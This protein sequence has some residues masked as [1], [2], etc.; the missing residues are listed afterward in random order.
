MF[1]IISWIN[2]GFQLYTLMILIRI[3]SSWLPQ[4]SNTKFIRFIAYYTDPYLNFFRRFV[5]PLGMFDF[6]PIVAIFCL[7]LIKNFMLRFIV[8]LL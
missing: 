5:P 8:F 3:F 6:S 2:L 7:G 4:F 1:R